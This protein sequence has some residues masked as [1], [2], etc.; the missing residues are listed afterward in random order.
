[1]TDALL[2]HQRATYSTL[3]RVYSGSDVLPGV[4][5]PLVWTGGNRHVTLLFYCLFVSVSVQPGEPFRNVTI[6]LTIG[7]CCVTKY[8]LFYFKIVLAVA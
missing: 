8:E 3:L 6:H 7:S 2:H 1:M 4:P 5:L